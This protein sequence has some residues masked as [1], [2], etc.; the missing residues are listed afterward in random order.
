MPKKGSNVK[1]VRVETR[2]T[3][4]QVKLIKLLVESE[5]YGG[6][7]SEVIRYLLTSEIDRLFPPGAVPLT[8]DRKN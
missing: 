3:E 4:G 8:N 5:R 1:T 6:S 2:L 7:E